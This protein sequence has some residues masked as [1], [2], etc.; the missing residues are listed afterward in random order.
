M[1]AENNFNLIR[2]LAASQVLLVHSFNH[3]GYDGFLVDFFKL[4][5]GVPV[6]F[7]VSGM[8]ISASY[9]RLALSPWGLREF[10][11]NRLLRIY[12][13]LWLCVFLS[14]LVVWLTGYLDSK[15][16]STSQLLL[17]VIG[18]ISFFQ[19]YNPE[20]MRGFGVGVLNG[21]LWT[22][23]VE[24]QF[25]TLTPLLVWLARKKLS[26]FL[27][28]L[29]IS[30]AINICFRLAYDWSDIRIKLLSVSFLPWVYMFMIGILAQMYRVRLLA[31]L[32]SMGWWIWGLIFPAYVASMVFIGKFSDNSNNAIH[33]IAFLLL[34][35]L[36]FNFSSVK[37]IMP[38]VLSEF[39]RRNDYS[40]GIYI[41]HT[42]VL[43][44]IIYLDCMNSNPI[45]ELAWII[46]L[47]LVLASLSWHFVENRV[48]A[49]KGRL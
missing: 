49:L 42:P 9:E 36:I 28:A 22:I 40:Y 47:P 26:L 29:L 12:P 7:F 4:I 15:E 44:I 1:R 2:L 8:L 13:A 23:A 38:K 24:L 39:I 20:F 35:V 6:F 10:I 5:P 31:F 27:I 19:F 11:V 18:Q 16:F 3:L 21:A 17:W 48:L 14:L 46:L 25:Y 34:C 45:L 30:M 32:T 43:N 37:M 41:F 33:P